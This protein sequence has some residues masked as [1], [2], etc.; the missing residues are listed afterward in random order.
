MITCANLGNRLSIH[1]FVVVG[2]VQCGKRDRAMP[3]LMNVINT[4]LQI[5]R[6]IMTHTG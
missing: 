2:Q 5:H 3:A 4:L 6:S 1:P